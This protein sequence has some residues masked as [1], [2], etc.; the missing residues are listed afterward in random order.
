MKLIHRIIINVMAFGCLVA[1]GG[2]SDS[3]STPE[4]PWEEGEDGGTEEPA[5]EKPRYIWIDAAANFPDYANSKENI[6]RDLAKA[7]EAGFTHIVV[8]VR[9]TMGDVLFQTSVVD[10]VK[11]LD[12]WSSNGYVYH[13]RTETWDY[14]QAFIDAGHAL[15]LKINAGINTFVGGNLYPYGL[16]Q[17]GML[18][19]DSSKKSWATTLN[20]EAGLTNVMDLNETTDPSNSYGTKF[21]NPA[22][23]D[24]QKFLLN[25][26]G[27]LAKYDLDGIFLDRGRYD[28]FA[29]DFSEESRIKFETYIGETVTNFPDDIIVPGTKYYPLP[30][31]MP[32]HFKK[33]MEFRAKVI[34]DFIAKARDK[35]KSVQPNMTFGVYVGGWYSTYYEVGVNWASPKYDPSSQY[36]TWA[37][38]QYKNYG[39]ADLL[40]FMLIGAYASVDRIYGNGEWTMQGFCK[41]AQKLLMNDVKFAGGPDVGNGSGWT[42]GGQIAKIP[43]TVDACI[44]AGDGY[45]VFDMIHVKK[46]NYWDGFKR[47][48]DDYLDSIQK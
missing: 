18:F 6:A 25:M 32:K 26:L 21:L 24:V 45:F 5:E 2:C 9:P 17:Q 37:S 31:T 7:K 1:F 39:Y 16:G 43:Q 23:D 38:A 13:E 11:K 20:L 41:N 22:N 34:H 3:D 42:E 33:W 35:V 10:Q 14:L 48:F 44:H 19:R 47:G 8:D 30:S 40:D 28:D 27:D 46:Y 36:P 15:G 29:S 12:V 4:W